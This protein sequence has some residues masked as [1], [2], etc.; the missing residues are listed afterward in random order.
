MH[1]LDERGL[2]ALVLDDLLR[3]D[4]V[5]HLTLLVHSAHKEAR[6]G[7]EAAAPG[8]QSVRQLFVAVQGAVVAL[9]D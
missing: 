2:V 9:K 1:Y 8:N 7:P 6:A 3:L 4:V 5:G